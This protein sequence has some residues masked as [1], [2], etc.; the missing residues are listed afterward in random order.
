VFVLTAANWDEVRGP[1]PVTALWGI[2]VK[3]GRKLEALG[4]RRVEQLAAADEAMMAAEFGPNTGPWIR[5]LG[6][7][8][9]DAEVSDAPHVARGHGRERT[10]QE[11]LTDPEEIRR[12]VS[13][14]AH[15]LMEDVR[16]EGRQ[17]IRVTVK[18]RFVP[19]FTRQ[20]AL[21]LEEPT[22]DEEAIEEGAQRALAKFELDRPVRLLGVRGEFVDDRA[23][24]NG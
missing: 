14:L 23:S 6:T 22:E 17:V 5:Q 4:I 8:E 19:F 16:A 10:F 18:V 20:H 7:G 13:R 9:D 15:E 3:T 11:D 24:P 12:E 2:G 21:K 1:Q